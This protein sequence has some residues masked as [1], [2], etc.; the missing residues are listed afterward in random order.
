M[1]KKAYTVQTT[2]FSR[3]T[4]TATYLQKSHGELQGEKF[5]ETRN[6]FFGPHKNFYSFH[7]NNDKNLGLFR[8][9]AKH[10]FP[11]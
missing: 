3:C 11:T 10:F 4:T 6:G 8:K 1:E 7:T 2:N 9:L 5:A